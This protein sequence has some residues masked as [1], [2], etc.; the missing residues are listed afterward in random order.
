M[1]DMR[2]FLDRFIPQ[3]C[4]IITISFTPFAT[5]DPTSPVKMAL[6]GTCAFGLL[7]VIFTVKPIQLHFNS[8]GNYL[9]LGLTINLLVV[10]FRSEENKIEQFYGPA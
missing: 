7:F 5:I 2:I 9:L 1:T 6:L 3:I 8:L 10:F 4:G